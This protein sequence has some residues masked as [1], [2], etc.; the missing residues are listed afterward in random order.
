GGQVTVRE[1]D[2]GTYTVHVE[3][4]DFDEIDREN[5]RL[6]AGETTDL[7]TLVAREGKGFS[8]RVT[9]RAGQPV[10]GA[11]VIAMWGGM[12]KFQSRKATSKDDGRY[13]VLGL[14]DGSEARVQV[15]KDGFANA[16]RE[17]VATGDR[18]IDFVLDRTGSVTGRAVLASGEAVGAFRVSPH[19]E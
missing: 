18:S 3:P 8:G 15:S 1:L 4:A 5:V 2:A 10:A 9:D 12:G 19:P 6:R 17:G 7:G 14:E 11:E 16:T 13:R